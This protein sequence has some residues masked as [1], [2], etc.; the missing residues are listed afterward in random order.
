MSSE[1]GLKS[2]G[3]IT[4]DVTIDGDLTVNGNGGG[5]YDEIVNGILKIAQS[6]S[7]G[8]HA[9]HIDSESDNYHNIF[10][11]GPATTTAA[12]IR[13]DGASALT[14]GHLFNANITSTAMATTANDG[15]FKIDH[16]ANSTSNVNNLMYLHNNHASSTG[17]TVLKL[18]Q[19]STGSA[20][21][22]L[23]A[24]GS[25]SASGAVIKLQ[26]ADTDIVDGDYLG[27]IEFSAPLESSGSDAILAGAA[28]WAEADDTFAAD[29]NSTELVFGT[30]TSAAY[31][32]RMRI[33]S[34]GNVTMSG[35]LTVNG[36]L[37]DIA[38][39]HPTLKLTDIAPDDN[40]ASIGYSDGALSIQTNAGNEGG[41]ADTITFYTDG[42]GAR[43]K[44][45][46]NSRISLSNN[47][48]GGDGG[49]DSTSGN[50]ILGYL[51]GSSVATDTLNNV[52]L[53]HKAGTALN[54][55]D[56]NV[57]IGVNAGLAGTSATNNI[58][59][60]QNVADQ[61]DA[62]RDNVAIGHQAFDGA[63]DG[64]DYCVVIGSE[65]MRGAATQDGTVA[66]G[67]S[68]LATLTAGTGNTAI[69]YLAADALTDSGYN[70]VV[71]YQALTAE[72][73]GS[74]SV[75]IGYQALYTQNKG[76]SA[77][78]GNVGI[79]VEAGYHN[80]QGTGNVYIGKQAGT[81]KSGHDNSKNVGIG[82]EAMKVHG[83]GVENVAIGYQVMLDTDAGDNSE[84]SSRNV[85]IG[86][87]VASGEW[88]NAACD[89]NVGIGN[90][91]MRGA[92][93]GALK[94][95]AVGSEALVGLTTGDG[96]VALGYKT[97]EDVNTGGSNIAIGNASGISLTDGDD[98]VAI[99][100]N[101]LYNSTAVNK[102]VIIGKNA[103][104][105]ALTTDAD[106]A[107]GIGFE[108]LSA[109]TTGAR[110][111]AI[112][113]QALNDMT[114]GHDNI[115]IGYQALDGMT[116]DANANQNIG[117]GN[118]VMD[119]GSNSAS[120]AQN[121]CIGHNSGTLLTGD[122]NTCVGNASG[123]TISSGEKNTIIGSGADTSA[124]TTQ[125]ATAIGYGTVTKGNNTVTLGD[126]NVDHVY[127][128]FDSGAKVWC[129][130]ID[131]SSDARIKKN[132]EKTTLGL[133]FVNELNPVTFNMRKSEEWDNDLK[134]EQAWFK[135]IDSSRDIDDKDKKIGFIAQEVKACLDKYNVDCDIHSVQEDSKIEGI[136]YSRL[137][138]PLVKA[139]QELSAKVTEL[140][141]KL[142]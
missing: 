120:T 69:G 79:G 131:S 40:Y 58:Y 108:S 93:D 63:V 119:V 82:Y 20:L 66:I 117:I 138:V 31:T 53:G 7:T 72:T 15:A 16:T 57:M 125:N 100:T 21:T 90:D 45:D 59:I 60:G 47:D 113:Y 110:N 50:T 35:T 48:A 54:S 77:V 91:I 17:T 75:A 78:M 42:S 88:T 70:T 107:I 43:F 80:A 97:L 23:G 39:A 73:Q 118:Y 101:C 130:N 55:G 105:G 122:D 124:G 1:G 96:N 94:N 86:Y 19:D 68:A 41:A 29:N 103:G 37:A 89:D 56:S 51:A 83:T 136:D 64:A 102:A 111:L 65:A 85:F 141:A 34:D 9:L 139:V 2:G 22:A 115:A 11:E 28:I 95:V 99:G 142:K 14:T 44:L 140:E 67:T 84:A 6:A 87:Q 38:G 13:I 24:A 114:E 30:N 126:S 74:H 104:N 26:T 134:K 33:A 32:E 52:L 123:D 112:G 106:G 61:A 121:V 98:N 10:I 116:T 36:D 127:M 3:T 133:N 128:A 76:S 81:G 137:V 71:G 4:G 12:V 8:E 46:T 62:E 129:T 109:L 135:N 92:L 18:V 5:T 49:V 132:V 25:G 27:R